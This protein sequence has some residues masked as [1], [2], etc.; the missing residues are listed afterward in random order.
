MA[1][2]RLSE[3]QK[4]GMSISQDSTNIMGARDVEMGT[5]FDNNEGAQDPGMIDFWQKVKKSQDK[6]RIVKSNMMRQLEMKSGYKKCTSSE[7]E[8]RLVKDFDDLDAKNNA[9]LRDVA[10]T[11]KGLDLDIKQTRAESNRDNDLSHL[12]R[13]K[14]GQFHSLSENL[15]NTMTK[16]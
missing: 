5:A 2:D 8:N 9:M 1:L 12:I 11:V 3:L 14:E 10:S 13:M 16:W 4:G 7:D 6:L 15:K